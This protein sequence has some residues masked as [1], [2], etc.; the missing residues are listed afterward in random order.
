VLSGKKNSYQHY[1]QQPIA[2][3]SHEGE[4]SSDRQTLRMNDILKHMEAYNEHHNAPSNVSNQNQMMLQVR[5]AE[6]VLKELNKEEYVKSPFKADDFSSSPN[7][8][9][10]PIGE[11]LKPFEDQ[12]TLLRKCMTELSSTMHPQIQ[13]ALQQIQHDYES[14]I[15][16]LYENF[17][18][19]VEDIQCEMEKQY[20][21]VSQLEAQNLDL[22]QKLNDTEIHFQQ[23]NQQIN[24]YIKKNNSLE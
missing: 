8:S 20:E 5:V 16:S 3:L 19:Q 11:N 18:S 6:K 22:N 13:H 1:V 21:Q 2:Y 9:T 17:S 7:N 4:I 14:V 12:L 10:S 23:R 15:Q 24:Q